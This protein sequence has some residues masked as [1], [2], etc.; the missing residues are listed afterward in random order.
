M[1]IKQHR[2]FACLA[3]AS[4]ALVTAVNATTTTYTTGD[5]FIGFHKSG[6]DSDYLINIGQASIYS[7][8][9][10]SGTMTLSLGSI[11]TDLVSIFGSGWATDST[12]KWGVAG[13]TR[14]ATVGADAPMTIYASRAGNVESATRAVGTATAWNSAAALGTPVSKIHSMASAYRSKDSTANSSVGLVQTNI[15]TSSNNAYASFQPSGSNTGTGNLAFG[16]FN[17]TIEGSVTSSLALFRL[18][19]GNTNPA[20]AV[21]TFAISGS[22][23]SAT[24]SFEAVPEPA[25]VALG[26]LSSMMLMTRRRRN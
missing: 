22:G 15:G 23:D 21:G 26:L 11:G 4:L 1:K 18:L 24:I 5:L 7:T 6:V 3:L 16:Y 14:L 10:A 2:Q 12:V 9:S 13:T 19:E 17:P 20:N 8:A 25:S